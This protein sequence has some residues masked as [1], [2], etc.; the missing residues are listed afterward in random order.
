MF[1]PISLR[2]ATL[3]L[4]ALTP[5]TMPAAAQ[6]QCQEPAGRFASIEG[7]I[8]IRPDEQ[9]AWRPAQLADPLCNGDTI[10]VGENSRAAVVL[11]NE[12]VLRL[13]QNT[14]LRLVDISGKTE[15]RSWVELIKGALQSFSRKPRLLSVNTPY[16][17]GSIE[18]TEFQVRVEKDRA[19]LLVLEGRV[20]T[21]NEQGKVAVKPGE[22]AEAQAGKAP[23]S[24]TL[25]RPRDAVQWALYYP[26]ILTGDTMQADAALREA[27]RHV[28][29]G[30]TT[31]AFAA[32][33]QVAE[34][35][36]DTTYHLHR[37]AVLLNVGR[38]GEARAAIDTALQRDPRAPE[39][40]LAHALR[41]IIHV[42]QNERDQALAHA[43][44]GVALSD[45]A[46]TRIALSYAQQADFR[47]DAA[48]DTL[49]IAVKNYPGDAL[50]WARLSEV[51]LMLGE[52]EL[53]REAAA[54][55][56][57]IAPD[58]ARAQL[59]MGFASL[60]DYRD[61]E[62]RAS[63]EK[64]IELSPSDPLAHLGMGLAK[65]SAGEL[66]AGRQ[67]LEVAVALDSNQAL[68]RAYLGK[69]YFEERR[70]TL[71][72]QQFE[73]AKSLDPLDPTAF[74][75]DGIRQ[76]TENR[77]V[78]ALDALEQSMVLNDN[79]AV[80]RSRLL[81]DKDRAARATSIARVYNDLGFTELGMAEATHA[82]SVDPANASA[83]RFLADVYQNTRRREIARV[84][85]LT[86]AQMLQ[87]LNLNPIQPSSSDANLNIVTAG[88]PANAGFNEF[89]PLFQQ[90]QM[91]FN[92]ATM[93]GSQDT[94]N[95]E[96]AVSG[97]HER[98]SF[99]LGALNY[100]TD[101]WRPN[102]G[103]EQDLYNLFVQVAPT[104]RL[105]VQAEYR[106]RES[107][108]GD[109]AFNFDPNDFLA[110]KTTEREQDTAR[111]GLRYSLAPHSQLLLSYIRTQ[112]DEH[113]RSVEE[114]PPVVGVTTASN[115]QR[116]DEDADQVESQFI[117][118]GEVMNLV[119]GAAWSK[120]DRIDDVNLSIDDSLIG[121][122][123]A[124]QSQETLP[125]K[126]PRGY[127][128]LTIR[129]AVPLTWTL[130]ASYDK[131]EQDAYE[132][133]GFNP[134]LGVQWDAS[135]ALRLRAAAFQVV[136]PALVSNRTLEPTQ[137]AGFNQLFDDINGTQ[138]R[139][140][141][142]G[143]DLRA[144]RTTK[145]GAEF[146]YRSLDEPLLDPVAGSW[147]TEDRAEN[148]H[149]LYLDWTPTTRIAVHTELVYDR[150]HSASGI[151][152]EFNNLP[153]HVA[154]WSLPVGVSYFDPTGY[155][156][157]LGVTGVDQSVQRSAAAT[158]ASG[159]DRFAVVDA[160][161]GYRLS[162]R[163]GVLSLAVRNLFDTEFLYQDDSYR[164]FRDEPSIGPYFPVRTVMARFLVGF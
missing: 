141:A 147:I 150:Y 56:A 95:V 123:L 33:D 140:Y 117:R 89:T 142:V 161:V 15:E 53:S 158:Q 24:R 124:V 86:Q 106:R 85:E 104:D 79:R 35:A 92:L 128:Y 91:Q 51:R 112:R 153:E 135:S 108:E 68:L 34:N 160:S 137:V 61:T 8:Q 40:G 131:F 22:I 129:S 37:A 69:A 23:T 46:A 17:N 111:L 43:E 159:D 146:S 151:A 76:Q 114:L 136:K 110:D 105:N 50:A 58:L 96:A 116:V 36:R 107:T 39:A 138:S 130:G 148:W 143:L 52:K 63:F 70:S 122:L 119:A 1:R 101:G 59:V 44:K 103:L 82:L 73:I 55:S 72:A 113:L 32:L 26:P 81:L 66:Q 78:E 74:L 109:L 83:H 20:L 41:A 4:F 77:P 120:A 93:G 29:H 6:A 62:A 67:E 126:H 71:D 16:L 87:D 90:N 9:Q 47:I 31:A 162:K 118:S 127:A 145:A 139:R 5:V 3:I 30:D 97:V 10:R 25:V 157:G 100:S 125:S 156:A 98:Y 163:R 154:T 75:Y 155:F 94:H 19:S 152:T 45:T 144:S 48:R 11:A 134:K 13:D 27:V 14:T 88:G 18:G 102:N 57:A 164:E 7:R 115:D 21:S 49:L 80:Y 42:V 38:Q 121:N 65:I 133:T 64:A 132:D 2:G 12:A 99:S 60:A 149:R 28:D 84:S 54:K